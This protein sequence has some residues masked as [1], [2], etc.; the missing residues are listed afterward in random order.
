MSY[1]VSWDGPSEEEPGR[2]N[3][4]PVSTVDELDAVLDRVAAQAT[5]EDLPYAVQVHR[6]GRHGAV[7]FGIGHSVR[8][9]LDWLDRGQPHGTADRYAVE[10]GVSAASEPVAFD[11]YGDWTEM[12]PERTRVTPLAA[13]DAAREFVRTGGRPTCV[14]W[15]E[16]ATG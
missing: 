10:P 3:E 7:M 8:S 5:A 1:V 13:R 16:P 9:F 14:E 2:G 11:F 4:V 6:P 12:P 15:V